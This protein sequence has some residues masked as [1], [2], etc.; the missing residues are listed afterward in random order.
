MSTEAAVDE[1]YGDDKDGDWKKKEIG[2][3]KLEKG[4]TELEEPAVNA[5]NPLKNE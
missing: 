2:R 5:D 1:L 3:I 4:I